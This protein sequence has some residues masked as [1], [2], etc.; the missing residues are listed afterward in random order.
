MYTLLLAVIYLVFISLGL[1]D[2]L[3]GSGWPTMRLVFDQ[4]LS[5]AGM[6]SMIITGGTICSSLLS[7]RLT[8]RFTTK[9]VT[10]ASVFLSA[11]ALFGFSIS[12]RFWMLCLW[13]VP[14]GLAA[15]CIDSAINNYVALHYRS[16]HMSWL[17]CFWGVGTVISPC[18]MSWALTR[19]GWQLGYRTVALMQLA[20]GAVLVL[21]LPL[22]RAH[23]GGEEQ[24]ARAGQVLGI[25]GALKIKGAPTLFVGFFAYCGAEGTSILWASSYLAGE[26]GFSAEHAAAS[27]AVL[28]VGITLGRFISGFI[29]DKVGDRGMIRLGTGV[30]AAALA[31]LALPGGGELGALLGLG[32]LGLGNAPVYP[33]IIHATPANFGAENSQGIIGM[34]MASAYVGST[35]MP[36]LF[37]L[38]A[39]RA[40]LGWMPPFLALLILLMITM[41]ETT[42]RT[43]AK[44]R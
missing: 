23:G 2:S 7:E 40:G 4:P 24:S 18:V 25:R 20:I 27:A 3:L 26:R 10:V 29:A 14:Y 31:V 38:I 39:N 34:Q 33:A 15:G 42:F 44:N 8:A 35:L 19:S 21:T 22:W 17:H 11:A 9:G 16:R 12:T 32:L 6:V 13:A 5:A 41:L 1:P 36:P 28:Y 43:V 37:G 30:V